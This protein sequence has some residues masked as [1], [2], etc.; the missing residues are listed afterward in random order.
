MTPG[1]TASG[2]AA[3][4]GGVDIGHGQR[5]QNRYY[6][7]EGRSTR[8]AVAARRLAVAAGVTESPSASHRTSIDTNGSD[9]VMSSRDM[10]RF[11]AME[12]ASRMRIQL[13]RQAANEYINPCAEP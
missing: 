4:L 11:N 12:F 1:Q 13:S 2:A 10:T 3:V 9:V 5:S 7:S 8:H 6:L